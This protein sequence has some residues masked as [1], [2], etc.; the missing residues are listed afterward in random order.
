VVVP[1]RLVVDG[2][3]VVEEPELEVVVVARQK[4]SY[5]WGK[6]ED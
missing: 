2:A 6:E 4:S 5:W 1:K 3:D